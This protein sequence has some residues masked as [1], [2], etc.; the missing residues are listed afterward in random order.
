MLARRCPLVDCTVESS[1]F[2]LVSVLLFARISQ[3]FS[4]DEVQAASLARIEEEKSRH[5]ITCASLERAAADLEAKQA[6]IEAE[7]TQEQSFHRQRVAV[8]SAPFDSLAASKA[9]IEQEQLLLKHAVED[10]EARAR[11]AFESLPLLRLKVDET[12]HHKVHLVNEIAALLDTRQR[13][14]Q[15]LDESYARERVIDSEIAQV[16]CAVQRE[17]FH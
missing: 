14:L 10:A 13:M 1:V 6:Q 3:S 5:D 9:E 7:I 17:T 16:L 2:K 4:S 15:S 11:V 12:R 8:I